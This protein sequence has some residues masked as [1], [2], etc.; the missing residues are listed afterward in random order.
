[1][2]MDKTAIGTLLKLQDRL[3]LIVVPIFLRKI[4]FLT[5]KVEYINLYAAVDLVLTRVPTNS[6]DKLP[7]FV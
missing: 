3:L 4:S 7:P 2:L 6:E 5:L 1:M